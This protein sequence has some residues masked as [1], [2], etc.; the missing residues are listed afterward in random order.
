MALAVADLDYFKA[1]NDS[2]G[3]EAG[4][5]ALR[6]FAQVAREAMRDSDIIARWGG[7][8]FVFALPDLGREGA[9]EVLDRLRLKLRG[10][11]YGDHP[12]FTVSFGVADT[13]QSVKLEELILIADAGLYQSKNEGRDRITIGT[14]PITAPGLLDGATDDPRPA[15]TPAS[16]VKSLVH[17]DAADEDPRPTGAEIR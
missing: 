8:E 9:V 17:A 1:V 2:H 16:L 10:A 7:E 12:K 15:P 3:H 5:R 13:T 14:A 4:D 6:L 11:H